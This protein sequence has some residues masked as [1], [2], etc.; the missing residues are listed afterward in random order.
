MIGFCAD[1]CNTNFGGV[2]RR[3]QND[4]FFNV[5]VNVK[6]NLVGI[7]CVVHIVHNCLQHTVDT[8]PTCVKSLVV[9]IYKSFHLY[10]VRVSKLK[11]FCNFAEV[12]CKQLL[13]LFLSLLPS[14]DRVLEMFK[15][16]KRYFN[17]EE[18]CPTIIQQCFKNPVQ[19]LYL[20]FVH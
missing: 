13:L 3:K 17:S 6:R 12:E 14:L 8:L 1:N 11:E 15:A 18:R 9:K 20:R 10:T 16:L 2:K 5:K 4:V 7:G 19:E